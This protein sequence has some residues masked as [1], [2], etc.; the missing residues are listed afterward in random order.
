MAL[1]NLY[2]Y[3]HY[4]RYTS[5]LGHFFALVKQWST[6]EENRLKIET[7]WNFEEIVSTIKTRKF[8]IV[9]LIIKVQDFIGMLIV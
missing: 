8:Q 2:S 6:A 9:F 7:N 3:Q 1:S 5:N 4:R